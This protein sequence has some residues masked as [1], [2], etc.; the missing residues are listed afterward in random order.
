[1]AKILAILPYFFAKYKIGK[2]E[3]KNNNYETILSKHIVLNTSLHRWKATPGLN[4]SQ[5][6]TEMERLKHGRK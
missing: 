4:C 2:I 1:M 3:K 5:R 6:S